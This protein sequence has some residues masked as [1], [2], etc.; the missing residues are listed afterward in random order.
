[1]PPSK[2]RKRSTS[3]PGVKFTYCYSG[4]LLRQAINE[5]SAS[6]EVILNCK[7][8]DLGCYRGRLSLI[9]LGTSADGSKDS[10]FLIDVTRLKQQNLNLLLDFLRDP[11]LTKVVFD[12]QLDFSELYHTYGVD[13][14]GV[15]DLQLADIE[16]RQGETCQS[17]QLSRLSP[18]LSSRDASAAPAHY[19]MIHRL[20][21]LR[22]CART[23]ELRRRAPKKVRFFY[24]VA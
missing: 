3:T 5:L 6:P 16:S 21:G 4:E 17:L 24:F 13:L 20:Y 7:G 23:T 1:M 11:L 18:H 10:I 19:T 2:N 9:S 12:G 14:E 15:L 8:K 22:K